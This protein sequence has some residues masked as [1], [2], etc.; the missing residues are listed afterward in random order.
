MVKELPQRP[1]LS[2]PPRLRAIHSVKCL[3]YEQADRPARVHPRRADLVER[4][5][6]PQHGDEVCDDE[7][8]AQESD[9]IKATVV[10][11]YIFPSSLCIYRQ[12]AGVKFGARTR[13]VAGT[14]EV[15]SGKRSAFGSRTI[16]E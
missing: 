5:S 6:V 13:G 3:V 7:T 4:R 11:A 8:E 9:L 15:G 2:G 12:C 14:Y 16:K 1:A 10:S